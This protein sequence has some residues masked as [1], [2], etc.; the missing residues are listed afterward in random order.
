MEMRG[1][2]PGWGQAI[3]IQTPN[4]HTYL[5]DTGSNYPGGEF[6]AGKE[7]IAPFLEKNHIKEIDGVVISHSHR[8]HFGGFEYLMNNYKIKHLYDSGYKFTSDPKYDSIYKPEYIS[9][10]DKYKQVK[11]GDTLGWDKDLEIE[12]LSPPKGYITE[13]PKNYSDPVDHHNPN[14]NSVV[15]RMKYKNNVFLFIGDSNQSGQPYLI[16]HYNEKDLK[17]TVLCLGHGGSFPQ[18]AETVKPEIVVESCLNGVDEPAN[19]AKKIYSQVGSD[20]YATC[21]NGTVQVVSDGDN[22]TVS[23]ERIYNQ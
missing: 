3:V 19:Q 6:D 1:N 10:G 7:M 15:M 20:V 22:C 14:A 13:D 18:F 11:K 5:Y 17:A 16:K 4:G 9:K 12:I 23:T 21:W 2:G 8:D